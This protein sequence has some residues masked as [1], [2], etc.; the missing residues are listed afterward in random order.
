MVLL[1]LV[2]GKPP[3][4]KG[5]S[6]MHITKEVQTK[7]ERGDIADIADPRLQGT[8]EVN[9]MWRLIETALS[10]TSISPSERPTMSDVAA[11]LRECLT[12][13]M[14]RE[15]TRDGSSTT[16]FMYPDN[17]TAYPRPDAR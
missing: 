6:V 13:Q 12:S 15:F 7:L 2:T 17:S 16:F 1:Q 4:S 8:Y 3:F 10:C 5:N 9:S 14:S 11:Q